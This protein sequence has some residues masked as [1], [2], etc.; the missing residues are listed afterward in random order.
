MGYEVSGHEKWAQAISSVNIQ[1]VCSPSNTAYIINPTANFDSCRKLGC[2][3]D[4]GHSVDWHITSKEFICRG[5]ICS[6][7]TRK[8]CGNFVEL[9]PKTEI[10]F[11]FP[12][13]R[14]QK[15]IHGLRED[16]VEIALQDLNIS[17]LFYVLVHFNG[18]MSTAEFL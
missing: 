13:F 17:R 11:Q 9:S 7:P 12:S 8:S 6:V 2:T 10:W 15:Q 1:N 4:V 16:L 18:M 3:L 5:K 14:K